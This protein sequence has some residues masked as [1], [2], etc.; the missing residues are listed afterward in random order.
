MD[1]LGALLRQVIP[2][3][4]LI[5]AGDYRSDVVAARESSY[6]TEEAKSKMER[7]RQEIQGFFQLVA[8]PS[9]AAKGHFETMTD[10][11]KT[12]ALSLFAVEVSIPLGAC[13]LV[14]TRVSFGA[15]RDAPVNLLPNDSVLRTVTA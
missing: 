10:L 1:L 11:R 5:H 13:A 3:A 12:S 8:S 15:V 4:L 6:S 7:T 2:I 9:L 14:V